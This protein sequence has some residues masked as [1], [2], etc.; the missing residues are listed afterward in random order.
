MKRNTVLQNSSCVC[1]AVYEL[2]TA[3]LALE[4]ALP[5]EEIQKQVRSTQYQFK[6]FKN[7]DCFVSLRSRHL[8]KEGTLLF[9]NSTVQG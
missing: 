8:D 1:V 7:V 5:E 4:L 6:V 2:L 9:H 3:L